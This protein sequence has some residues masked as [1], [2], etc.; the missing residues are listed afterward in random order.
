MKETIAEKEQKT[1]KCVVWD[2]DNTLWD[3][4]LLEDEHVRVKEGVV[5]IIKTLDDRGILHSIASKNEY[6]VAI[7][8]LREFNLDQYFLYPQINWSA[9]S[10]SIK[11]IA[12]AININP[13]AILFIDDQTFELQEVKFMF[14]QVS[15]FNAAELPELLEKSYMQPTFIT[16]DSKNRRRMYLSDVRRKQEEEKFIGPQEAFLS[17]LNMVLTIELAKEGDLK[18]AEELTVRTHQLNTTGYTFSYDELSEFINSDR[19]ILMIASLDDRFGSYGKI[20]LVLI[21]CDE[22]VWKI[23]LLL[24][25]CRVMSRGVGSI[26]INHIVREARKAGVRLRGEFIPNERNRIMYI[27]YKFAGFVE[28]EESDDVIM[29]ENNHQNLQKFPDYIKINF[30]D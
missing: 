1:I 27:T 25:S 24:M 5:N 2:L 4:V 19:H 22:K 11:T 28:V 15:C 17:S 10:A 26:I 14:P 18:R 20:G 6:N 13:D 29:F 21:E 8:K 7:K 12:E 30:R 9:K 23:K 16:E 3:G